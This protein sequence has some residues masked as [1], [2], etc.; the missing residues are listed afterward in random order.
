[1]LIPLGTNPQGRKPKRNHWCIVSIQFGLLRPSRTVE[2]LAHLTLHTRDVSSV[3]H[4]VGW[5][6]LY[7]RRNGS[8]A[9]VLD[10]RSIATEARLAYLETV[11]TKD[12]AEG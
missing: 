12:V 7:A 4:G 8:A 5:R 10:A 11:R 9:T 2:S 1:M 3:K 6:G